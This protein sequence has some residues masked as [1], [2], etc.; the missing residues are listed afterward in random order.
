[1]NYM[2]KS[3]LITRCQQTSFDTNRTILCAS[4]HWPNQSSHWW[5][6]CTDLF[7]SPF[8]ISPWGIQG[9]C[10]ILRSMAGLTLISSS[11]QRKKWSPRRV[12][13]TPRTLWS[14]VCGTSGTIWSLCLPSH[15]HT[16]WWA[17]KLRIQSSCCLESLTAKIRNPHALHDLWS[18]KGCYHCAYLWFRVCSI[19]GSNR[20]LIER[21][22]ILPLATAFFLKMSAPSMKCLNY[23]Y[24]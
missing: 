4:Y 23:L 9:T 21:K 18:L 22:P 8:W 6:A 1:M 2:Q 12:H 15:P 16:L 19:A 3:I 13:A 14:W 5:I 11:F 20:P 17:W 7:P 10:Q 24:R